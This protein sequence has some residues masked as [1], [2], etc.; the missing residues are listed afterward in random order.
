[1]EVRFTLLERLFKKYQPE[2]E[3]ATL[4]A[5]RS[6]WY[7][8]G[9]EDKEFER[10]FSEMHGVRNCVG[11]GNGLDALS[12]AV[13]ALGIG[14]G[15][16]IIVQTN[17]FIASALAITANG[18]T[19]VFVDVDSFYGI[20]YEAIEK[21]I[22]PRTKAI[23]PV[24]LF[25]QMCDMNIILDIARKNHLYVIEDCAQAHFSTYSGRL[26]GTIGDI[27]C[28]SFYPTKTVAAFGDAGAIIT[29][30]DELAKKIRMLANYGSNI[31]YK[32]EITGVNTRLDE[33]QAAIIMVNMKHVWQGNEERT[34]IANMY[35]SRI[36]NEKIILPAIR[37]NCTHV[38]Y[39]FVIRCK[40]R[41]GLVRHLESLG[42]HTQIHYP[43]PCHLAECYKDFGYSIGDIP[44][45]EQYAKE[46]LSL[47]IYVGMH[48]DEV[49]YV[50]DSINAYI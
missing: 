9:K 3:E 29:N 34:Q 23:M 16:E 27:G 17:T 8:L 6:G 46:I 43:I 12:L 7:I 20:S 42:V 49:Q 15:D 2:Y 37:K 41:E 25:G 47:P 21:A 50:I 40:D 14:S 22:T 19:P 13:R 10:R 36:R 4:G 33:I 1:M 39:T 18:A 24:H 32:H 35:L 11:L 44:I 26:A 28:F 30:S 31:K 5:L 48:D 38:W 45:A